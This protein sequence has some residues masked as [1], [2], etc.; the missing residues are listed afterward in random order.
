MPLFDDVPDT[1]SM[2]SWQTSC[3]TFDT[4]SSSTMSIKNSMLNGLHIDSTSQPTS[5]TSTEREKI[6][7][8]LIIEI[9]DRLIKFGTESVSHFLLSIY[10]QT[11]K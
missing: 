4:N 6:N 10:I 2:C 7:Y 1:S 9:F 5:T 8:Q 3:L 11:K